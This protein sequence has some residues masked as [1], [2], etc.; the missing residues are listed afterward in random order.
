MSARG[1]WSNAI[2]AYKTSL[3]I[4]PNQVPTW[5]SL[6]EVLSLAER[7]DEAEQILSQAVSIRPQEP[8]FL[9]ILGLH[10]L[11]VGDNV[12]A[13]EALEKSTGL[14]PSPMVYHALGSAYLRLGEKAKAEQ[15]FQ[16]ALAIYPGEPRFHAGI[17][18]GLDKLYR[19]HGKLKEARQERQ[20][21]LR[22]DP[23]YR[24]ARTLLQEYTK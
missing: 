7:N 23:N 5:V 18:I 1:I 4:Y 8:S 21:A 3:A 16:K 15:A 11:K 14:S 13:V 17:H 12:A 9:Y 19:I 2:Q 10:R 24:E 20:I 22:F 6:G